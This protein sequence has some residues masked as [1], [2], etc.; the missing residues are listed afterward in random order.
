[1]ILKPSRKFL[2][3]ILLTSTVTQINAKNYFKADIYKCC[4]GSSITFSST[5]NP[6]LFSSVKWH[7]GDGDSSSLKATTINHTYLSFGSFKASVIFYDSTGTIVFNPDSITIT[8]Y[9]LPVARFDLIT[10]N[11]QSFKTN[12]F[13]FADS[14]LPGQNKAPIIYRLWNFGDNNTD[15]SSSPSHSYIGCDTFSPYLVVIDSNGCKDSII[16]KDFVITIGPN[17]FF[18]V[19]DTLSCEPFTAFIRDHSSN[20]RKWKYLLGNSTSSIYSTRPADSIF[21][22]TYLKHGTYHLMM[23]AYDS[24]FNIKTNNWITCSSVYGD[25]NNPKQPHFKITVIATL[26]TAFTGSSLICSGDTAYFYDHSDPG[27]DTMSW[28]FGDT[29]SIIIAPPGN[30]KHQYILPEGIYDKTFIVELYA[31]RVY[32]PDS[33]RHHKVRVIKTKA[34]IDTSLESSKFSIILKSKSIVANNFL[35]NIRSVNIPSYDTQLVTK[36]SIINVKLNGNWREIEVCLKAWFEKDSFSGCAD[37]TC[38]K[39]YFSNYINPGDF[40]LNKIVIYPNPFSN[41]ASLFFDTNTKSIKTVELID[42]NGK[43]VQTSY[44]IEADRVV[45]YRNMLPHGMYLIKIV[46]DKVYQ[47]KIM[48]D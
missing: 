33:I 44:R 21:A 36:D 27:Y 12:V 35:W 4:R 28:N 45:L 7:F 1:M 19:L 10:P 16:K 48:I 8:V 37:D 20:T 23:Y 2:F 22:L 39:I 34:V 26:H 47:Q 25:T 29:Q 46:A 38:I 31:I 14:S 9:D 15:T 3:L 5:I 41:Q 24:I 42:L 30:M 11:L 17:A 13:S 6:A 18:E 32:C 43:E 40:P